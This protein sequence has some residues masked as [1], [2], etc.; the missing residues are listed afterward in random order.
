MLEAVSMRG[1]WIGVNVAI[2][3]LIAGIIAFQALV[4][5]RLL[6]D[7]AFRETDNLASALAEE[8]QHLF[9]GIGLA[10]LT[11]A[12]EV[13]SGSA[14]PWAMRARATEELLYALQAASPSTYSYYILDEEGRLVATSR[15]PNLQPVDPSDL[16]EF[17]A[18]RDGSGQALI[19]GTPRWGH[20]GPADGKWIINLARRLVDAEGN[21]AGMAAASVSVSYMRSF[22]DALRVGDHGSIGLLK[23]DGT[24]LLRSPFIE[25]H[26]G[27]KFDDSRFIA[28]ILERGPNGQSEGVSPA[29]GIRRLV[30]FRRTDAQGIVAFVGLAEREVLAR[31]WNNIAFQGAI[32]LL[33]ILVF[34]SASVVIAVLVD[35]QRRAEADR[36]T[37]LKLVANE[38]GH[39]VAAPDVET[40]LAQAGSIARRLVGAR[41]GAAVSFNGSDGI[42]CFKADLDPALVTGPDAVL[43]ASDPRLL[44]VR[45]EKRVL[46]LDGH[47]AGVAA[48]TDPER[49]WPKRLLAVPV[50]TSNGQCRGVIQA[51]D[52]LNGKFTEFDVHELVQFASVMAASL[53]ALEA[54]LALAEALSAANAERNDKAFILSSISDAMYL[55]DR[56][57]NFTYLNAEA[58]RILGRTSAQLVGHS[59]WEAF[60]AASQTAILDNYV[61]ARETG[62]P[63]E[64]ELYYPDFKAWYAIRGFPHEKGLTSYLHDISLRVESE[65]RL[66][67]AQKLDAIGQLTGGIAHDFNNLLTVIL[68]QEDAVIE[69]LKTSGAPATILRSAETV[70]LAGERAAELTH[71]LLAY[72]R[73]QPLDPR[74]TDVNAL[75][76]GLEL[77]LRRTVSESVD[78][79]IREGEATWQASVDPGELENAVL[80]LVLNARDAMSDGGRLTIETGNIVVDTTYAAENQIAVGPYVVI[81]VS[82]TG[83]GMPADVLASAFEPF[84]TTKRDGRGSG[85]GLSMVYGFARQSGGQVKIYS[86]LGHGT[87]VRIYLPRADGEAF[88]PESVRPTEELP[89]GDETILVLEDDDLVRSHTVASL[90][91]LGYTVLQAALGSEALDILRGSA[92]VDL[93]LT[94]VVLPG[95]ASGRVI[96]AEAI[97]LRPALRILYMSGYTENS[98]I[99]HGRLDPGVELL[100][101][102]FRLGQLASKIRYILDN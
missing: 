88:V 64:F 95:T 12:D 26:I 17:A 53:E 29:D 77:I 16:P 57:W 48:E 93:L 3:L 20:V 33:T 83:E 22:F 62:E 49:S 75:I 25:D 44:T 60:P 27:R 39:L 86:E 6:I 94:D 15:T 45:D 68:G 46:L 96:A 36:T 42:G 70:Q 47:G 24:L 7:A 84:F 37:R 99:H 66:R 40:L 1:W 4:D 14:A 100:S 82:D 54:R 98:I 9:G 2:S 52:P 74:P 35:R 34:V 41:Q 81:A 55:L 30:S 58:E 67:Q 50:V 76:R 80:N 78:I 97:S 101:K 8:T 11:I 73:R 51:G 56:D 90:N 92:R 61:K 63:V 102:P 13:R 23:S 31:W 28:D 69:Y 91:S 38:A 87:T 65:R 71:R 59:F 18:A 10:L 85:L 72:A 32:G 43:P 5:R 21:F 19:I 79:E 89:R